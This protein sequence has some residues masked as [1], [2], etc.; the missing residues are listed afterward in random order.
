MLKHIDRYA[1]LLSQKSSRQA[2]SPEDI[3]DAGFVLWS[4][5][6][7]C[8]CVMIYRTPIGGLGPKLL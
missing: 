6:P 1:Q 2:E 3:F 5:D 7:G 4:R 8:R